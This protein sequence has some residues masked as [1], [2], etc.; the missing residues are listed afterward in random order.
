MSEESDRVG[1]EP[2]R[3]ASPDPAAFAPANPTDNREPLDWKSKYPVE[4]WGCIV[5]EGAY[6]AILLA[7]VPALTLLSW[8]EAPKHWLGLTDQKY[9]PVLKYSLAWLGGML[10][11]TM[12]SL[13]WLYHSVARQIWHLD[14]RPWR[15]FTPHIS[16][17]LAFAVVTLVSSGVLRIFDRAATNSKPLVVGLS[18]LVGYFSDS[19]IAKLTE[20]AETLFGASRGKE[21]HLEAMKPGPTDQSLKALTRGEG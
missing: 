17:G 7:S 4:A 8:T 9:G 15:I 3:V 6:L 14:R 2:A 18:F 12:F 1:S 19:A 20:I 5:R 21:K 16:G 10:G 13:K 11:G